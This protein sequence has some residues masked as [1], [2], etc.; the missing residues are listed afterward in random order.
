MKKSLLL[1]I[2]IFTLS[3]IQAKEETLSKTFP[4]E[5][6]SILQIQSK[7]GEIKVEDWDKDEIAVDVFIKAQSSKEQTVEKILSNVGVDFDQQED[8]L[9]I[10]TD[11][12]TFF[13]FM[14]L[15]NNLFRDGE[16]AIDYHIKA[17]KNIALD[18]SLHSG[19][20]IL[21][22]RD[23]DVKIAHSSGYV[24]SQ[25]IS[26]NSVFKLRDSHVKLSQTDS[27]LLDAK[28]SSLAIEKSKYIKGESYHCKLD[29]AQTETLDITSMRDKFVL[30]QAGQV[31]ISSSLSKLVVEELK[32]A[33]LLNMTYGNIAIQHIVPE[34]D[35]LKITAKATDISIALED[36]PAHI[37]VSHHISTKTSIAE[38]LGLQMKFGE[39]QKDFITAGTSGTPTE[40]GQ[41][42]INIKGGTLEIR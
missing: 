35:E 34:F 37:A 14:N 38:T 41:V 32:T 4:A 39:T 6:I 5:G 15:S 7:Y 12:G 26:G 13:S 10:K 20:I 29:V 16:F 25:A 33:A 1:F 2:F 24:S 9:L 36:T 3:V 40:A 18:I 42:L 22:E 11:F 8:C 31:F 21:F 19:D 23:A 27:L 17:P 30:Q 28:N